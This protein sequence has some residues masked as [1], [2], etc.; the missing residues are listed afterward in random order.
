MKTNRYQEGP[1][2]NKSFKF[3]IEI[4]QICKK[5]QKDHEYVLSKQLLRSGTAIGAIYREAKNAQSSKDFIHKL[6][7][8]Q[9]EADETIFWLDL[10]YETDYINSEEHSKLFEAAN[11][12]MSLLTSSLKTCKRQNNKKRNY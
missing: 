8:S 3:A 2:A 10:L 5:L 11:E 6:S 1:T 7:L 9:K 4:V 12:L